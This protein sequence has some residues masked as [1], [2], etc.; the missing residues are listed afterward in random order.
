LTYDVLVIGAGAAGEAAASLAGE[1]KATIAV[2]EHELVGGECSFWACMPSKTL[3]DSAAQ[4]A[5]GADYPWERAAKRRDWMISRENIDYPTDDSH[6]SRL[7]GAGARLVRGKARIVGPGKVEV[8]RDKELP[9]VLEGRNILVCTGSTPIVPGIDGL[10]DTGYWTN[11]EATSLRSLPGSIMIL[12]GGPMGV[13]SA[14][15][16]ARFGVAVTLIE[17]HDRILP[18]DHPRSSATVAKQIAKEG[19]QMRM[20]VRAIAASLKDGKRVLALSDG[21]SVEA[22]ELVIAVGRH[23]NLGGLGLEEVGAIRPEQGEIDHDDQMRIADGVFIAGDAAGGLQ[24]THLADY[25]G[26]I[27]LRAA[28]GQKVRADLGSVPKATYTDPETGAVGLSEKEAQDAGIDAFEVVADFA[29]SARGMTIEGAHGHLTAV[30]DRDKGVLVGAFAACKSA[31][32][33]VHEAVLAIKNQVPLSVLADTIH[34]F[35]TGSRVFGNLM[36]EALAKL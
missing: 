9:E 20:N 4:R 19:V 17:S 16:F 15:F 35:P 18:R 31:S 7:E 24:F 2:V 27:A 14:Q 29:A 23:S 3:L 6:V 10:A 8:S 34:A 25:E 1:F 22:D 26:R 36:S 21:S 11:R 13:E 28:L 12:G 5:K 32:E 30:V 33:I